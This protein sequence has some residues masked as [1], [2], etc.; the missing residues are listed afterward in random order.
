METWIPYQLAEDTN[1][2]IRSLSLGYR[3]RGLYL[4]KDKAAYWDRRNELGE[5]V[6]SGV[7]IYTIQADEFTSSRR[8][9]V[10]R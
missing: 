6:T 4:T 3:K 1:V 9:V 7:Y 2:I 8:M 10:V 5:Q